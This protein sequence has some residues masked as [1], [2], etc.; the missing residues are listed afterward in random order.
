MVTRKLVNRLDKSEL[1]QLSL[2]DDN[3]IA[4]PG[5]DES[6]SSSHA[7][8]PS[9]LPPLNGMRGE[10]ARESMTVAK[11]LIGPYAIGEMLGK[12]GF[13]CVFKGL[14]SLTGDFVAIKRFEK[15]KISKDQLSS[16]MTELE[17]LQRLN[18]DNVVK[19]LGKDEND[20]YIYLFLEFME[21]GSLA[22]IL[23]HFGTFPEALISTYIEQVLR[24]LVYLHSENIIHRDIKAAN[25]LINKIGDAKLAD[26]NVAAE[27][28]EMAD[29]RYSVVGTPYWMAPEVIDISGHCTVS[30][31]WSVGC[32]IIELLT[33]S[34]PYFNHN[35]M[36]AMF[37]IVQD[38]RPPFPKNISAQLASFL[39]RC[40]V[41]S[42]D[43]RA[44]AKE[45]LNH[46]WIVNCRIAQHQQRSLSHTNSSNNFRSSNII[47][48]LSKQLHQFNIEKDNHPILSSDDIGSLS[49][50]SSS[51][52]IFNELDDKTGTV[53]VSNKQQ[54]QQQMQQMQQQ[55]DQQELIKKLTSE[56]EEMKKRI[57]ELEKTTTEQADRLEEGEK[58]YKE[59]LLSSMH[60]INIVDSTINISPST[61]SIKLQNISEEVTHLR[62]IM[63]DQI[64]TEYFY[65]FPEIP[66]FLERRLTR[67]TLIHLPK[68]SQEIQKKREKEEKKKLEKLEKEKEKEKEKIKK[69]KEKKRDT[70]SSSDLSGFVNSNG[71]NGGNITP[72]LV[73]ENG[74]KPFKKDAKRTPSK[75]QLITAEIASAINNQTFKLNSVN[76]QKDNQNQNNSNNG[77][78]NNSPPLISLKKNNQI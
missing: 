38:E 68:K 59:I 21:N 37:R 77:S 31:I 4:A 17:L 26:F 78:L 48:N 33:G 45:L 43:E 60:Y 29:K 32:T 76:N 44:D 40:F 15:S 6:S 18:H 8:S 55:Q 52:S 50:S 3:N 46:E 5:R 57:Q 51:S 11:Q 64:E 67:D 27:L 10:K 74:S 36:A 25:I 23:D 71:N 30:D 20:S 28:G 65:V 39:T 19:V 35:P 63:R 62:N 70:M 41:K 2:D 12:G 16:V 1:E 73:I 61:G 56:K 42:V 53:V 9:N 66:R 22:S 14:N 7:P 75:S 72:P 49:A 47:D 24:G 54:F 58:K 69:E 34:P 13:A